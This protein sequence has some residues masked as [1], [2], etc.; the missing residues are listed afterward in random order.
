[1]SQ[2]NIAVPAAALNEACPI[3][4]ST[5]SAAIRSGPKLSLPPS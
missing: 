3:N 5:C 4:A 1:M 2:R